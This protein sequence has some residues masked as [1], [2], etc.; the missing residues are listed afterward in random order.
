MTFNNPLEHGFSHERIINTLSEWKVISYWCL[1]DEV[2]EQ[3][4]P[5][6]HLYMYSRNAVE[7][8]AVQKRFYGAHIE[9]ARGSHRENRDYI[10]KEGKW[11]DNKKHETNLIETFEESGDMPPEQS[12]RESVSEEILNMLT[13]GASNAD[14]LRAFPSS[15]S[16]L[17]HIEKAR[18]TLLEDKYCDK[19]RNLEV[20]Y[21]YGKPGTG[22]TRY[23]MEKFGYQNVYRI[24]NYEHPFDQ[25]A[26]Q[27]VIIFDEF[28]SSLPITDMLNYLDGYPLNLPCRY[29]DKVACY[30]KVFIISNIPLED[31]Y[32]NIQANEPVTFEAFLRRIQLPAEEFL[33]SSDELPF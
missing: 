12:K 28:R 23:V 22:K 8:A 10:R 33:D 5:H 6:T 27:D 26:G 3:G 9:E 17:Q 30:T 18:Q 4:T 14:I 31:Q 25:Y 21:I 29:A 24:S 32:P 20:R 15:L 13:D 16:K 19:W 11:A 2:G 7:F 1:C